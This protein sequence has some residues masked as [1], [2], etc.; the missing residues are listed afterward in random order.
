MDVDVRAKGK[1]ILPIS[2][3]TLSPPWH[4]AGKEGNHTQ[5]TMRK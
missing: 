2:T 3:N 5:G 1:A 4:S